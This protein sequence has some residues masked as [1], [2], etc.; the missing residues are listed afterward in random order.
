[1]S[2]I[3]RSTEARVLLAAR[4]EIIQRRRRI[5]AGTTRGIHHLLVSG[6]EMH[7][8]ARSLYLLYWPGIDRLAA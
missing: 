4:S 6:E 5:T 8:T 7:P 1:M 2:D 3:I